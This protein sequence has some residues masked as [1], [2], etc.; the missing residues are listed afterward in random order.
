MNITVCSVIY[1]E[2]KKYIPEFIS[3]I[4]SA[5]ARYLDYG[6]VNV[7]IVNDG[8]LVD[9]AEKII[10]SLSTTNDVTMIHSTHGKSVADIRKQLLLFAAVNAEEIIV[11]TDCDDILC[12]NALQLHKQVLDKYDFS[13]GDQIL[14]DENGNNLGTSLY[15][16]WDVPEKIENSQELLNGNFIGFSGVAI[17]KICL[18]EHNNCNIPHDIIAVDWW[19]FSNLLS[20][21]KR[22]GITKEP[23]VNYRQHQKNVHGVKHNLN[24]DLIMKYIDISL[25]HFR[26]LPSFPDVALR[27][28]GLERLL[29]LFHSEPEYIMKK[30]KELKVKSG[31]L[32]SDIIFLSLEISTKNSH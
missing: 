16:G 27:K 25:A 32:Y 29:Q 3:G 20:D 31:Y 15:T 6:I 8:M 23:V 30:L 22:G 12:E 19:F 14:I 11:F 17:N 4:Q 21:G 26:N 28:K 13:Y 9:E 1:N 18:Q 24:S 7:I 10:K 5:S 2:A